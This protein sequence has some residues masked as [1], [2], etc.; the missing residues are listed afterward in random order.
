MD[1]LRDFISRQKCLKPI[2]A[3]LGAAADTIFLKDVPVGEKVRNFFHGTLFGHPL[4][5]V[6]T[7]V[8]LSAWAAATALDVYE[9]TT[10]DCPI[11]SCR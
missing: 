1:K 4:H 2:E 10:G 8:P 3:A 9:L 6:I 5:P 11:K 7:D